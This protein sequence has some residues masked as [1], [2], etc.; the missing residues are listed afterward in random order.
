MPLS[1]CPRRHHR[2]R[3]C[4]TSTERGRKCLS[5]ARRPACGAAPRCRY[6]RSGGPSGRRGALGSPGSCRAGR[7]A[8][9]IGSGRSHVVAP[10]LKASTGQVVRQ[11]L[12]TQVVAGA[13]LRQAPAA[14]GVPGTAAPRAARAR[15]RTPGG[16]GCPGASRPAPG[17]PAAPSAG[18]GDAAGRRRGTGRRPRARPARA[19]VQRSIGSG[20][21]WPRA[22]PAAWARSP[23]DAAHHQQRPRR[24]AVRQ[25]SARRPPAAGWKR[26][27][28]VQAEAL[29][30]RVRIG[31]HGRRPVA[32]AH[33][34]TA[35][36]RPSVGSRMSMVTP[37]PM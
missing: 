27:R 3:R 36:S 8:S 6:R 15:A 17:R 16:S 4:R 32:S 11:G 23:A 19:A 9:Q 29:P 18:T 2:G 33:A 1:D 21:R 26:P 13:R 30:E 22:P 37:S 28:S 25:R 31:R 20:P 7:R 12:A 35:P 24:R 5:P 14:P 10:V 34:A